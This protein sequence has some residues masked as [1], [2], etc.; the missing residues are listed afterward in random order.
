MTPKPLEYPQL[1]SREGEQ[2]SNRG[3]PP[4]HRRGV[5]FR[6][7]KSLEDVERSGICLRQYPNSYW[8]NPRQVQ[9]EKYFACEDNL[10]Y[11]LNQKNA[12]QT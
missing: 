4:V 1:S 2:R 12:H 10:D 5:T 6:A 7:S 8:R 3:S 9:L 11:D